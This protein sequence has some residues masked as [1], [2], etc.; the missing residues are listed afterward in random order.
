MLDTLAPWI[1]AQHRRTTGK[2]FQPDYVDHIAA[3]SRDPQLLALARA[4]HAK[5]SE[6]NSALAG[7]LASRDHNQH[8]RMMSIGQML[9]NYEETLNATGRSA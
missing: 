6:L 5:L 3:F 1:I 9:A 4:E 2:S 7:K 8:A